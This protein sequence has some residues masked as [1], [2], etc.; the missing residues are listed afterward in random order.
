M[1]VLVKT[2]YCAQCICDEDKHPAKDVVD[3]GSLSK[4]PFLSA[5][6]V[7]GSSQLEK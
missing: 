7:N 5:K 4:G 1:K 3:N 2:A 6:C